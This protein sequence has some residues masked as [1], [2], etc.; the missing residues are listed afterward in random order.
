MMAKGLL[1]RDGAKQAFAAYVLLAPDVLG[2]ALIY[3]GPMLFTFYLSFF[4]WNGA[5]DKLFTGLANY[6]TLFTDPLW[7]RSMGITFGYVLMYMVLIVGGALALSML[8]NTRIREIKVFRTVYFFPIVMPIIV[9]A[10]VWQFIYEPSY[11]ILN[12]FLKGLGIAPQA[13]LGS[14]EQALYSVVVISA[15]KQVGYYMVLLLAGLSDIPKEY[16]EASKI[17]GANSIQTFFRIT[18]PLLKPMLVFV[19]VVN[20]ITGLQDFDQVYVL[21]RGG[22]NYAT[23]VQVFYI[24]E[25]AFKFLKM[26]LASAASVILFTV[27]MV[28]SLIQLKIYRGG[29]YD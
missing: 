3:L 17:D 14:Q 6:R 21:T 29:K 13:F 24:Y 12:Y 23:Y 28:L 20:L 22:P 9:A 4:S 1:K 25:K 15:W 11:G 19:I 26:G 7:L 10:I 27:I 16:Y 2:L 8:V 18:L 5:G